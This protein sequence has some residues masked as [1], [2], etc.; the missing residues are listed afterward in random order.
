[1]QTT[2]WH[3]D[4]LNRKDDLQLRT[5]LRELRQEMVQKMES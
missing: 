1:M 2:R 5:R 4:D 3:P